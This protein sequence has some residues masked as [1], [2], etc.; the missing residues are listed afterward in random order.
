[1]IEGIKVIEIGQ[2]LA[3]P[4][5]A[6]VLADLGAE[7]IKIEKPDGGDD[8]RRMGMPYKTGDGMTFTEIN[9][10]KA[11]VALDLKSE[12]GRADL[13]RLLADADVLIHNLRPGIADEFELDGKRLCERYPRLIYCEISGFG[14]RGPL[15]N[16]GAFEPIAQAFSG[17]ISI[18]GNPDGPSARVGAPV[19]DIGTAMWIVIGTLSALYRRE[20]TG[21]GCLVNASLMETGLTWVGTNA[22]AFLNLGQKPKRL[23]TA[24][25]NLVPYQAFA[26]TD[27]E[28]LIAAGNDRL[29]AKLAGALGRPEWARDERFVTNRARLKN[30]EAI[31]DL[32]AREIA[33]NAKGHWFALLAKAGVPCGPV[34]T[35]PEAIA[36]PQVQALDILRPM[37]ENG[38]TVAGLPL[39]FDGERPR[40][41]SAAPKLG[42]NND[43]LNKLK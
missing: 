40:F 34:N 32:V 21:K 15:K 33:T 37:P 39:R 16:L 27:G 12:T 4:Y 22:S 28:I 20:Q 11:S 10:N 6:M 2:V 25:P 1:M 9:R 3:A 42:A 18:N 17:L 38:A 29:F 30:R 41:R 35:V 36:D 8:A 24:N 19:I 43:L 14:D 26:T 5:A 13:H 31:V 23:G 7:V